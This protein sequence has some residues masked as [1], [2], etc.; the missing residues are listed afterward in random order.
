MIKRVYIL[1]VNSDGTALYVFMH[2]H[3]YWPAA[4]QKHFE[5]SLIALHNAL[6]CIGYHALHHIVSAFFL[7]C[8]YIIDATV[9][10]PRNALNSCNK[11]TKQM[12]FQQN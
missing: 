9:G 3:H 8:Y 11:Q 6:Y 2:Q 4:R 7:N 1:C 10:S 12:N 5:I